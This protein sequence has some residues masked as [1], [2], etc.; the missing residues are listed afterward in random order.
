MAKTRR[1]I[2]REETEAEIK[3]IARQ[4]MA[5]VGAAALSLRA[6]ARKLGMSAPALYRYFLNRDALV[7]ALII[8]AYSDLGDWMEAA[9]MSLDIRDYYGRFQAVGCAYREWAVAHPQDYT[10][11]YGTPIPGYHAPR[12]QTLAPASRVLQTFGFLLGEAFQA[13]AIQLVPVYKPTAPS[14]AQ[15]VEQILAQI[16]GEIPPEMITMTMLIWARV[17]GVL[18]G[19]LY[20]HFIPG[21]AEHGELYQMELDTLC[22]ELGLK[23]I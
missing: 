10:L 6:I 8:D 18:W 5:E 13:G 21:M 22:F 23:P 2:K 14:L 20:N 9:N 17:H 12:E 3:A 15:Q 4:Q 16:E 19:E 1:E 11:I 7:T